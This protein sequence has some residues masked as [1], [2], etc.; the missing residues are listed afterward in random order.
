[1]K[2]RSFLIGATTLTLSQL[3]SGCNG[4]QQMSL[5]VRL[6][7]DSIPAQLLGQFRKALK[8]PVTLNFEPEK[9]LQQLYQD[10]KTWKQQAQKKDTPKLLPLPFLGQQRRAI[11]NLV[12]LGDYWLETAIR[13]ELIQPLA[14]EKLAGWQQLSPPWQA[15]VRRNQK[16]EPDNSGPVWGAPYRWGTTV[17]AYRRDKFKALGFAP[18]DWSDLWRP[19][20]RDRISL[21]DQPREVIGLTLKK[22]GFSYNTEDLTKVPDLKKELLALH[23]QAKFYSSDRYLEPLILEDTWLAVGWSTDILALQEQDRQIEAVVPDSGTSLWADLWVQPASRVAEP[24]SESLAKQW[25]DFC[26][27]QQPAIDISLVSNAVSPILNTMASANLPQE[28]QKNP[29]LLPDTSV[30]EKSEFLKPLSTKAIE[31]YQALWQEIRNVI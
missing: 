27:Q 6:L 24:N 22:M 17:I 14:I 12:T 18:K 9:Q 7:Q 4:K 30:I 2:R 16:G 23:Q 29:L 8:Q 1:M 31:Q 25:I 10:L 3:A 28:I 5:S 20:L 19:E 13:Q 26:W 15:L 21:L 11:P